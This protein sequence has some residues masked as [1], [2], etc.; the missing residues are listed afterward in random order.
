MT[1]I[2]HKYFLKLQTADAEMKTFGGFE[3]SLTALDIIFVESMRLLKTSFKYL[4]LRLLYRK[5]G[6]EFTNLSYLF[7]GEK[8]SI[9]VKQ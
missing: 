2:C 5:H 7:R 1:N 3:D 9:P 4:P 6:F 8:A